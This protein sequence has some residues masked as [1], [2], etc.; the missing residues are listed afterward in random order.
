MKGIPPLLD[1]LGGIGSTQTEPTDPT[2]TESGPDEVA[3]SNPVECASDA[4]SLELGLQA[5]EVDAGSSLEVPITMT[6]TGQV[7]CLLDVGHAQLRMAVTSGNDPVWTTD[8]CPSGRAEHRILLAAGAV[9]ENTITWNG[10]RGAQDCPDN[11]HAARKGTYRLEVS[12]AVGGS[13]ATQTRTL[14]LN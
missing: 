9:Q 10:R 14:T 2:T 13:E 1:R 11:T 12:L 6:N 7:P 3:L 4:V 5:T 8:Q